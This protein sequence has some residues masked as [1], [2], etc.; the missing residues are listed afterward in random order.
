[1][2][3]PKKINFEV[4]KFD[5]YPS[6]SKRSSYSLRQPSRDLFLWSLLVST[7]SLDRTSRG[8][9]PGGPANISLRQQYERLRGTG[10][11]GDKRKLSII[12]DVDGNVAGTT[13][14]PQRSISMGVYGLIAVLRFFSSGISVILVFMCGIA[15]SSSPAVYSFASFG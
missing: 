5:K 7:S 6:F 4:P 13:G 10:R 1:M 12:K 8:K 14:Q 9:K 11:L 15:V 3:L 2:S